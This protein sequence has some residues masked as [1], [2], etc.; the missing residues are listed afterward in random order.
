[1]AKLEVRRRRRL[2][3]ASPRRRQPHRVHRRSMGP[4]PHLASDRP[5]HGHGRRLA[6]SA[7]ALH[8]RQPGAATCCPTRRSSAT[9][10]TAAASSSPR[11]AAA[12]RS[13]FDEGFPP[14]D[15]RRVSRAGVQ[16]AA[17]PARPSDLAH[18]RHGAARF[19]VRRPAVAASNTAA[20]RASSTATEDL[21]CYWELAQPG[22]WSRYPAG[23]RRS[24]SPTRSPIGVNVLTYATNREPKGKEQSFD[25][26]LADDVDR[27]ERQPAASSRSPSS[28]TAAAATTRP[29]RW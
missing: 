2:E 27:N 14:T 7:G 9:T 20:A 28:A 8:Q 4:R 1:M 10:S 12:I 3:P 21:S 26:P 29:A 15:G 16:A 25:T 17:G 18:A 19:A 11:P 6:A 5:G 23:R 13:R 22:Q 24:T